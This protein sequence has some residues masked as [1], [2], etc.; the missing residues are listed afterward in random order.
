LRETVASKEQDLKDL[1]KENDLSE[2][3][4]YSEPKPFKSL[5]AE[6][7]AL[8][9]LKTNL[10]NVIKDQNVKIRQMEDLYNKNA[11]VTDDI[12][13]SYL[14]RINALKTEQLQAVV[15]KDNLL[16]TLAQIKEDTEVERKRRIKR[17]AYDN[18]EDRYNKDRVALNV[19]KQNT[20][21]SAVPFTEDDFDFGEE[22]SKNIQIFKGIQNVD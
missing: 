3:G 10:E 21:K 4:I 20:P 2:Q 14:D 17:A 5:S 13:Q 7:A 15:T 22:Q 1:K 9:S 6:N 11:N 12:K 18:E 16:S 19:I 8:E